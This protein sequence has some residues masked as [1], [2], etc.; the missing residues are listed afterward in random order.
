MKTD[1]QGGFICERGPHTISINSSDVGSGGAVYSLLKDIGLLNHVVAADRRSKNRYVYSHGYPR[2]IPNSALGVIGSKLL[3]G[4]VFEIL[5][6]PFQKKRK[7]VFSML[8]P[9]DEHDPVSA[10]RRDDESVASF[11]RRR[12]GKTILDRAVDPFL[13]GVYAGNPEK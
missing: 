3:S 7:G 12:L 2:Q 1:E 10:L 9:G 4:A 5:K 6:E 11:I 13:A 8:E